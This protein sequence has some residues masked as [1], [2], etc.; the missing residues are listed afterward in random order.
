MSASTGVTVF[1]IVPIEMA[2][3]RRSLKPMKRTL[4]SLFFL[5]PALSFAGEMLFFELAT[6]EETTRVSLSIEGED[7]NGIQTWEV[8]DAHGTTG[9]LEGTME[10]GGIL[11]LRH[12]YTIEGSDQSEEVIYKL[13]GDSLLLGEGELVETNGGL[14]KLKD[15]SQVEFTKTLMRIE[16]DAP[17]PGSPARKEIMEA[18]RGPISAYAGKAVE[19]TGDLKACQGWALFSGNVAAKDGKAPADAEAAFALDL[20]F[21]ALLKTDP[22]GHWQMLFWGFSGDIGARDEALGKFPQVP[23]VLLP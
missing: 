19:F 23:W 8:P 21:L 18:M 15:P 5:A 20:D 11:R 4:L 13:E 16:V 12:D 1:P 2:A 3:A 7:V 9:S 22:E 10:E 17:R 14:L 6:P